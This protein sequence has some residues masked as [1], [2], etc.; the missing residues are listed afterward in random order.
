MKLFLAAVVTTA[1]VVFV[2]SFVRL[3]IR[4]SPP[5]IAPM[6][7]SPTEAFKPS[8]PSLPLR[9]PFTPQAPFAQWDD[10]RQQDA[11]E[12]AAILMA[13]KWAKGEKIENREAARAEILGLVKFQQE[14]YTEFRDTSA[15]DTLKRLVNDYYQYS[16][17]GIKPVST[18][19]DIIAELELGNLV[20]TPMNGR[21]L[22]NPFFTPPGPERH[23]IVVKGFD[24]KTKEF[25][26]NDP[27]IAQ[28]ESYRYPQDVFVAAIG[29][30]PTGY[31]V[32][33]ASRGKK[34]IVVRKER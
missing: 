12:E 27:G 4:E 11:C 28:G 19:D 20:I 33:I 30:F 5:V 25:V 26:T 31:H 8:L 32:P 24:Q 18:A 2:V 10:P 22:K 13:M 3:A 9:V 6:T 34:M 7:D 29:D 17:S 1:L 21:K 15:K 14:K 23:M 16:K